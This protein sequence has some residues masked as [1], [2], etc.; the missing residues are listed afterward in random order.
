M[1]WQAGLMSGN[2]IQ[3]LS[4][5]PGGYEFDEDPFSYFPIMCADRKLI[6]PFFKIFYG[7][8]TEFA[9]I[10][11][12]DFYIQGFFSQA[13]PVYNPGILSFRDND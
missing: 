5:Y 2:P 11:F 6:K 10:F 3:L 9:N 1:N 4:A 7:H 13:I 12:P 8:C